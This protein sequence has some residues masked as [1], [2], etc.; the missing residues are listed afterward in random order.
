MV[1]NKMD[2]DIL[3][4]KIQ[5]SIDVLLINILTKLKIY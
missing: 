2:K 5:L 1:K 4:F 3:E